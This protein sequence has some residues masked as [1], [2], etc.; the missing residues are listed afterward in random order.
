MFIEL[1]DQLRCPVDH[2]ERFLVLLTS[3][4]LNRAVRRGQLGCPVCDR[5]WICADGV[6]DFGDG[7][8]PVERS[9]ALDGDAL[10]ALLGLGGPGGYVCLVGSPATGWPDLAEKLGGV[11]LAAVNPDPRAVE[12]RGMSLLRSA[13]IPLKSRSM[14]GVVLGR[15]FAADPAWQRE[16][17][18][19]VLP[20]LRVVGEGG[21]VPSLPGL[22]IL[23]EADGVW[24]AE[25]RSQ[26]Q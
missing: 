8:G 22:N 10:K 21:P 2:D 4:V 24:V 17:I 13:R 23:A 1:T 19:V 26:P 9:S 3:E 25:A 14:R 5:T 18:R 20:G 6:V 7:P 16:A 11:H 12:S 15:G